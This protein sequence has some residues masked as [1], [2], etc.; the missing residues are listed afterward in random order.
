MFP[1]F[2]KT[3]AASTRTWDGG[4]GDNNWSTCANWSGPDI[5]PVAGDTVQFNATSTKDSTIDS[6]FGGSV[7][8]VSIASTYSGIITL[9]ETLAVT[10][11]FTQSG[12]TWDSSN[13]NLSIAST[14]TLNNAGAIFK[15]SSGTTVFSGA[16][17]ITAGTFTHNSGTVDFSGGSAS[18]NCNGATFNLVNF[19]GQTA[20]KSI[21]S[22]STCT[23]PLGSNPT[24]PSSISLANATLS[25]S[26]TLTILATG[27]AGSNFTVNAGGATLSGFNVLNVSNFTLNGGTIDFTGYTDVT[28][29]LILTMLS[30]TLTAPTGSL[31]IG[32]FIT[33][34]GGTF[35]PNNGTVIFSGTD[36]SIIGNLNFYNFT[37]LQPVLTRLDLTEALK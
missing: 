33:A 6:L 36:Q 37:K 32:R 10:S 24:I 29:N 18:L 3:Y 4:G 9:A 2:N 1:V 12:G 23:F 26:G 20:T 19:T 11:T 25:G 35:I 31:H 30:G 16:F 28:I 34:I 8:V 27:T 5:C 21:G 13:Q 15:A 22:T 7:G 17:S 14:F